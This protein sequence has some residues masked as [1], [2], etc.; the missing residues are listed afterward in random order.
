M[1]EPNPIERSRESF[2]YF[3]RYYFAEFV[4][5]N[6]LAIKKGRFHR[7]IMDSWQAHIENPKGSLTWENKWAGWYLTVS[8]RE[9]FKST[10]I[11]LFMTWL[12]CFPEKLALPEVINL[13]SDESLAKQNLN[14]VKDNLRYNNLLIEDFGDFYTSLSTWNDLEIVTTPSET[15]GQLRIMAKGAH[16]RIRGYHPG[17][18][19]I[20]DLEGIQD[21]RGDAR[22]QSMREYFSRDV[23][24]TMRRQKKKI[25]MIGSL[26]AS[27]AIITG[28]A[29]G[30]NRVIGQTDKGWAGKEY[31]GCNP[32]VYQETKQIVEPLWPEVYDWSIEGLEDARDKLAQYPGTFEHEVLNN[33]DVILDYV[34][35]PDWWDVSAPPAECR[36]GTLQFDEKTGKERWFPNEGSVHLLAIDP[37]TTKKT[38]SD[39]TACLTAVVCVDQKSPRY[40]E[41]WI[42]DFW[43]DKLYPLEMIQK[44]YNHSQ[45]F[46]ALSK[47][48]SK[49]GVEASQGGV[50]Y[51]MLKNLAANDIAIEWE[52]LK[53]WGKNNVD[54][55]L[56]GRYLVQQH[57]IHI[58]P[59]VVQSFNFMKNVSEFP[60]TKHDHG[61]DCLAYLQQMMDQHFIAE[62]PYV[63]PPVLTRFQQMLYRMNNESGEETENAADVPGGISDLPC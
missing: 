52:P 17:L 36:L 49:A 57:R 20:D 40:L 9:T 63:E 3:C 27:S 45:F 59:W 8:P 18:L 30:V 48:T 33:P 47:A 53:P 16:M 41:A 6:K 4:T 7:E 50:F 37:A 12:A 25:I 24:M 44:V 29:R 10:L 28:I 14:R 46:G 38:R 2:A 31:F 23:L 21:T 58:A 19:V 55:A 62:K 32:K 54:R 43:E 42:V 26:I 60:N 1:S 5:E 22:P 11:Q 39:P 13:S 51:D 35:H 61:S 34:W 56:R 15:R